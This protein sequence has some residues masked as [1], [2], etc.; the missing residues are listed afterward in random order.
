MN[1]LSLIPFKS[2]GCFGDLGVFSPEPRIP[3]WVLWELPLR[4]WYKLNFDGSVRG[5]SGARFVVR[6]DVGALVGADS[7]QL[8]YCRTHIFK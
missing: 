8:L 2:F 6:N 4:S 3:K 5:N 1:L 7:F